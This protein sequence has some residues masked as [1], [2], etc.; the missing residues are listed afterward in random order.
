MIDKSKDAL[1]SEQVDIIEGGALDRDLGE[2][3][4][5]VLRGV[6]ETRLQ[7]EIKLTIK[8][9]P[10]R[11]DQVLISADLD[12]KPPKLPRSKSILFIDEDDTLI[13]VDPHQQ[14]LP[15]AEKQPEYDARPR[16]AHTNE[17]K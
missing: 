5:E 2:G 10:E 8:F 3:I 7:G 17:D 6:K 11:G 12:V 1:F 14:K 16:L 4:R 15:L 9:K 13:D